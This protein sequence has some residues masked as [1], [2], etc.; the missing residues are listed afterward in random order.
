MHMHELMRSTA[1]TSDIQTTLLMTARFS[2]GNSI[3]YFTVTQSHNHPL[4]AR[5]THIASSKSKPVTA[6]TSNR[7]LLIYS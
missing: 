2:R 4:I 5:Y 7:L 6:E 3:V 1:T